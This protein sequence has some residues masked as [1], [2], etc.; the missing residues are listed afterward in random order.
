MESRENK[1]Y[2]EIDRHINHILNFNLLSLSIDPFTTIFRK[3][4]CSKEA[5][6][7][8]FLLPFSVYYILNNKGIF[9][10]FNQIKIDF[11]L[12]F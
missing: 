3:R 10:R 4:I 11:S 5:T 1:E 8:F 6:F 2:T 12:R 7:S 9:M